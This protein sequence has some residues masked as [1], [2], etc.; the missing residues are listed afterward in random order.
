[1]LSLFHLKIT[2]FTAIKYCS[3]LHGRLRIGW[4]KI[5]NDGVEASAKKSRD[6]FQIIQASSPAKPRMRLP[7]ILLPRLNIVIYP[8]LICFKV[9]FKSN[10]L[11]WWGIVVLKSEQRD[12]TVLDAKHD[13]KKLILVVL[14]VLNVRI[15]SAVHVCLYFWPST[16]N[17]IAFS[18]HTAN[19]D[20][21][22]LFYFFLWCF[23]FFI[24]FFF[25][26]VPVP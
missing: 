17:E 16:V 5:I 8:I 13:S 25:E 20:S 1:M 26:T 15:L 22:E 14:A 24:F 7:E 4:V 18:C 23:I 19:D 6:C 11:K 2:I 3:I 12:T 10:L 21:L 9:I